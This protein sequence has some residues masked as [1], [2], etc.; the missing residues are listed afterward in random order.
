MQASGSLFVMGINT[1]VL[2]RIQ[3][4]NA[5]EACRLQRM[6]FESLTK[7]ELLQLGCVIWIGTKLPAFTRFNR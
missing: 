2:T 1:Q 7:S 4:R 5:K 3:E 6:L